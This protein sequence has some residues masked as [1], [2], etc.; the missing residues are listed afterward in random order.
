MADMFFRGLPGVPY[1]AAR[2]SAGAAGG[3][4]NDHGVS[5]V[6]RHHTTKVRGIIERCDTRVDVNGE[7]IF[8]TQ[9]SETE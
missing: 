6:Q 8:R 5:T 2:R 4:P 7:V 9:E 1:L 3:K